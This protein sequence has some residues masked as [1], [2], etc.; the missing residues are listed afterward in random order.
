MYSDGPGATRGP[1]QPEA[2][3][4]TPPFGSAPGSL[5]EMRRQAGI[6][7][8]GAGRHAVS[9]LVHASGGGHVAVLCAK[10]TAGG[11]GEAGGNQKS[12]VRAEKSGRRTQIRCAR[13]RA[14]PDQRAALPRR[15]R[16][17]LRGSACP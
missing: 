5:A 3:P 11:K 12:G 10:A 16:R 7:G 8:R 15:R 4:A 2:L 9:E 6:Y 1:T 14:P 17:R 13:A